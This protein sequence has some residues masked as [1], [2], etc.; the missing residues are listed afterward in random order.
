MKKLG[1][2]FAM[3]ALVLVFGL[4]F[5]GCNN[6]SGEDANAPNVSNV[7]AG[8]KS[9]STFTH[10]LTVSTGT[11]VYFRFAWDNPHQALQRFDWTIKKDGQVWQNGQ[12][13]R[14]VPRNSHGTDEEFGPFTLSL[15]GT[16]DVEVVAVDIDA[17][18]SP[19]AATT[20]LVTGSDLPYLMVK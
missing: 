19:T 20:I 11:Q 10:L 5:M 14:S 3:L 17:R 2:I 9:G 12:I 1:F 8:T 7:R 13:T 6:G 15:A 4:A 16:Y 18:R